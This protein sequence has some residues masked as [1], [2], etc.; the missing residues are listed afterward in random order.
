MSRRRQSL[1]LRRYSLS[2]LRNRR[3]VMATSPFLNVVLNLRRRIFSTTW[4]G[5]P[6][7]PAVGLL[8]SEFGCPRS[9]APS[10][11]ADLGSAASL[12]AGDS[13][14]IAVAGA[15]MAVPALAV[16]SPFS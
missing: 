2:P 8:G 1:P 13:S 4:A 14:A 9:R 12:A 15:A 16:G 6:G 10:L 7:R 11:G 3:R 5:V